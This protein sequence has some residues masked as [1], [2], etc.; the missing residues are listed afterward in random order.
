MDK[1]TAL[2][3][4]NDGKGRDRDCT[5]RGGSDRG[6]V[7]AWAQPRVTRGGRRSPSRSCRVLLPSGHS[8]EPAARAELGGAAHGRRGLLGALGGGCSR[9]AAGDTRLGSLVAQSLGDGP[10]VTGWHRRGHPAPAAG[11][12]GGIGAVWRQGAR[13]RAVQAGNG[14]PSPSPGLW[15]AP[16][17]SGLGEEVGTPGA[18]T[19]A[20]VSC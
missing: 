13:E 7:S 6:A 4:K 3:C 1:A 17:R 16:W 20:G 9:P 10:R 12:A 14:E 15:R 5:W 19:T 2:P 18:R 8:V 11:W